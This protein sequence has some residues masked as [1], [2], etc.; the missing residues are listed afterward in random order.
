MFA[1]LL[2]AAA[3]AGPLLGSTPLHA[4]VPTGIGGLIASN[5]VGPGPGEVEGWRRLRATDAAF[6]QLRG[7]PPLRYGPRETRQLATYLQA[8]TAL[9]VALT[10]VL[11]VGAARPGIAALARLGDL[12]LEVERWL[13][14][15]V[16][17]PPPAWRP[18]AEDEL[19]RMV[20]C[21]CGGPSIHEERAVSAYSM[22]V[23]KARELNLAGTPDALRAL[24]VLERLRP[25]AYPAR[26]EALPAPFGGVGWEAEP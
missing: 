26:W 15:E 7:A 20:I 2:V 16:V 22:A 24:A 8:A 14:N 13:A 10:T 17:P 21:D 1:V 25:E 4:D 3:V 5:G 12:N 18:P 6:G 11:Q 19:Y 23:E 9:E